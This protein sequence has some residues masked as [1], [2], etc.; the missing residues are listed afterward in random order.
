MNI[1]TDPTLC[2]LQETHF[3]F[4]DTEVQNKGM[5]KDIQHKWKT[6]ENREAICVSN[7]IDFKSKIVTRD[8]EDHYIMIKR[9]IHQE[10]KTIVNTKTLNIRVLIY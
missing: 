9:S 4:K 3:S 8:K 1:E 2:C 5:G 6:K 10:D 7:N